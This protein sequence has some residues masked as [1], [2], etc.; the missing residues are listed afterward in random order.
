M[1]TSYTPCT[2]GSQDAYAD[3]VYYWRVEAR[4][5]SGSWGAPSAARSFTKKQPL[6]L[7][8]PAGGA[9]LTADPTF[10]WS[11]VVGAQ[12][13]RLIVSKYA[14]F[15]ATYDSVTTEYNT[16]TPYTPGSWD[17][18][19]NGVYYWKVEARSASN[20]VITTSAARSF[21]RQQPLPLSDP[22]N[23]AAGGSDPTFLWGQV[24]GAQ[25]YR[26]IVSKYAD[27][28]AIFDTVNC[29][30]N[31]YTPYTAGSVDTYPVGTYYW[32]VEARS[33]TGTVITTSKVWKFTIGPQ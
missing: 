6:P 16:Y 4:N 24:V 3:G 1:Y 19:A 27:F 22:A 21:T 18:Y 13:Y 29:D 25:R 12:R 28:H 10:Q 11:P 26:L 15:H 17:A 5:Y 9:V 31:R 23:G 32:K 33:S 14:D 30:Y 8:A 2:A 20:V 7:S